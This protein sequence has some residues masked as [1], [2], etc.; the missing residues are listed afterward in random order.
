MGVKL[1]TTCWLSDILWTAWD[2]M[3]V[4]LL[5]LVLIG[6]FSWGAMLDMR[7]WKHWWENPEEEPIGMLAFNLAQRQRSYWGY[8]CKL[9]IISIMASACGAT[10]FGEQLLMAVR[11]WKNQSC[12]MTSFSGCQHKK[13]H[14]PFYLT[15]FRFHLVGTYQWKSLLVSSGQIRRVLLGSAWRSRNMMW[16]ATCFTGT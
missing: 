7:F 4:D 3:G 6:V 9:L 1:P 8:D 10:G 16:H 5:T 11:R 13:Y 15:H 2:G 14:Q 12:T